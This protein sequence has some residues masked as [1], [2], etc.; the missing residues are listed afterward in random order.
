[1]RPASVCEDLSHAPSS[2]GSLVV[3]AIP[4]ISQ[5]EVVIFLLDGR[6][7]VEGVLVVN[8]QMVVRMEALLE[9]WVREKGLRC[10]IGVRECC[11]CILACWLFPSLCFV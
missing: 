8:G 7:R 6:L 11:T 5:R 3:E 2:L 9:D 1:M 4:T 10:T